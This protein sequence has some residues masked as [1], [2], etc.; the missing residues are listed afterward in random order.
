MKTSGVDGAAV[1]RRTT[2]PRWLDIRIIGGLL[3]V[4]AAVVVGARVIGASSHTTAVWA[5]GRDLATGTV[6]TAGDLVPVDVN[7]GS[8]A[9]NYLAASGVGK[10]VGSGLVVPVRAGDLV[11]VSAVRPTAAGR[12][13]VIGVSPDRMPPG[14]THG[15]LIDLYL[16]IGGTTTAVDTKTEL[17]SAKVTVQSV[18]APASGGL[19]GATSN[20]YQV[21]VLVPPASA[22]Q[23]VKTLPRGEAFVALWS[24][25]R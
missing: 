16:I 17:I 2:R 7:L 1:P 22:D 25:N 23:L 18:S 11:P 8:G 10:I 19:S 5:A 6:L 3:L 9:G 24:G 12:I 21:A 15:S 4:I 20:R 14:V 13:V